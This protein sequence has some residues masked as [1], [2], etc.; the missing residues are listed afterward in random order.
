M[1]AERKEMIVELRHIYWKLL[2][3]FREKRLRRQKAMLQMKMMSG[4][5]RR[6]K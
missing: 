4:Y 6:V 3:S 5:I 2:T 1:D